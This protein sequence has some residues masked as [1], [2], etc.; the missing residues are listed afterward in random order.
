M[1]VKGKTPE[2][3][4][5]EFGLHSTGNREEVPES[6]ITAVIT[7]SGW[8]LI[9]ANRSGHPL[10]QDINLKRASSAAEVVTC[11]VEEHVMVSSASGWKNGKMVWS[12]THDSRADQEHL[13]VQGEPPSIYGEIRDQLKA[14]Q[15]DAGGRDADTDY[16]FDIPVELAERLTGFRHDKRMP[17][18]G[19][20]PF[21]VL[22]E[23]G[24]F[25]GKSSF[26]KRLFGK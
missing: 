12:V 21:E 2:V 26:L 23:K 14:K 9:V 5:N 20:Q 6:D 24:I 18:L 8:Y 13:S 25:S 10:A 22:C 17:E 7:P 16:L 19:N 1:G 4:Q 11:D 15:L 3:V